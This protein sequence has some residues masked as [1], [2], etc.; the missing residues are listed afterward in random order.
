[1]N[2]F[3]MAKE[4][5]AFRPENDTWV[6]RTAYDACL[7]YGQEY[8]ISPELLMAIIEKES[9]GKP[10]VYNGECRGL[11]QVSIRWHK[12][13]MVRLNCDDLFDEAQNIHV[14]TDYLAELLE[15]YEDIRLVLM[16]YNMK[17][18]TALK[19]WKNGNITPYATEIIERAKELEEI[20]SKFKG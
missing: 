7:K 9:S 3:G 16:M 5:K 10:N 11:M 2:T 14:A 18:D 13:R 20:H 12:E 17:K 15:K 6:S 19:N 4:N 1:M 8:N